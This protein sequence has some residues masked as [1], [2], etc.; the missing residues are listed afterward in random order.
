MQTQLALS[1][2]EASAAANVERT[3][4]YAAIKDGSLAARKIGRRSIILTD[5]L[6]RWLENLPAIKPAGNTATAG[7]PP[8]A[9]GSHDGATTKGSIA[10]PSSA[11]PMISRT[12]TA[13]PYSTSRRRNG[14][15]EPGAPTR[16]GSTPGLPLSALGPTRSPARSRII[17]RTTADVAARPPRA[18]KVWCAGMSCPSSASY[19]SQN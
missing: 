6:A 4:L 14:R 9:R 10:R 3:T 5:D 19:R 8:E 12:P 7:A 11:S 16:S 15:R 13:K 2:R 17:S 1:I 18:S